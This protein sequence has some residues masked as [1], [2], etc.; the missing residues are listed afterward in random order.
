MYTANL[1][2]NK[3]DF[4]RRNNLNYLCFTNPNGEYFVKEFNLHKPYFSHS[5]IR[6]DGHELISVS[7]ESNNENIVKVYNATWVLHI[8]VYFK[9]N[10]KYTTKTLYTNKRK[11]IFNI[12]LPTDII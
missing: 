4:M 11:N 7:N 5:Y 8:Q 3:I 12:I 10:I 1:E 9:K 6:T 2:N